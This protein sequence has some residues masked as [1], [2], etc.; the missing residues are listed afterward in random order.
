MRSLALGDLHLSESRSTYYHLR[1]TVKR[2]S[3]F[4]KVYFSNVDG[5]VSYLSRLTMK[6]LRLGH[7]IDNDQTVKEAQNSFRTG[8]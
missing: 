1:S 3:F 7:E 2:D 6:R 4:A 5:L 8:F